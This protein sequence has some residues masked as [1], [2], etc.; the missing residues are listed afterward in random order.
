MGMIV[1]IAHEGVEYFMDW[2]TIADGPITD[3][4]KEGEF[5]EYYAKEYGDY[6]MEGLSDRLERARISGSS[7]RLS[8]SLEDFLGYNRAGENETCLTLDQIVQKYIVNNT[9]Q[10][11][12]NS[13]G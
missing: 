4:M 3:G 7:S 1:C 5:R 9:Y 12:E 10:K 6:S 11:K 8:V 13:N 2:S